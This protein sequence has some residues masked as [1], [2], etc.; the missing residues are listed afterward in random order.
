MKQRKLGTTGLSISEIGMGTIQITRLGW[1]KSIDVVR[2]VMDLGVN[3]FD[4]ARGYFDSE[5]RLADAF[6]G[7]RDNVFLISKSGSRKPA[8]LNRHLDESLERLKTDYLDVFFF[9]GAGAVN[10]EG[11]YADNGL[12]QTAL[13][14][15]QAG[16]TRFLGFSAHRIDIAVKALDVEAF[17]VAMVPANFL[18][19]EYIDGEFMQKARERGV[20]VIAMKPFG[21]GRI[22]D[23]GLCLRFLRGYPEVIPCIGIE[24]TAEMIENIRIWDSGET[25]SPQDEKEIIRCRKLLGIRFCRGCGYCLPCPEGIR[26]PTVTFM[27]VFAKQMPKNRVVTESNT[28]AVE[29]AKG[30]TECRRCVERCPYNLDIPEMIKENIAFYEEFTAAAQ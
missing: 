7:V 6:K 26:I 23:A 12:L 8:E 1:Q 10:D 2:G 30:C 21:G 25:L 19:R 16:K 22:T 5:L 13:D 14:A 9:H 15:V 24:K 29:G 17:R 11:F 4:T 27:K 28:E 20:A 3:W 18:A